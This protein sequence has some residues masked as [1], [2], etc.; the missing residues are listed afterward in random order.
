MIDE[1]IF[2]DLN[3]QN[4]PDLQDTVL[5]DNEQTDT[6]SSFVLAYRRFRKQIEE[7]K[8]YTDKDWEEC[9]DI[10]RKVE[11]REVIF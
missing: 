4:N 10:P 9:F 7:E 1:Y 5:I 2:E 6:T 3:P 11:N 8:D